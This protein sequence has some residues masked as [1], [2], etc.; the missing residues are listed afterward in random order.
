MA[1]TPLLVAVALV[2]GCSSANQA[3]NPLEPANPL[4]DELKNC[5]GQASSTI[6][7]DGVYVLTTFG[8]P[9]EGQTM[10]CGSSTQ[11]GTWYYAASRQRYGCG[12]K[13]QLTANGNC[14]VAQT[15]DYGPDVCV[16]NAAGLPIIDASPLV[17]QALFGTS[18][19]G[20]SDHLQV[21]VTQV[22]GST[23][24]G[25][26]NGSGTGTGGAAGAGSCD[27][28]V[29]PGCGSSGSGGSGGSG[30]CDPF[31][32]PNCGYGTGGSGG[33]DPFTDPNCGSG[34]GGLGGSGG[35]DPYYDPNCGYGGGGS[36]GS[37]GCDP[38]Y[39]PNCGY[40]ASGGSS[41]SM[42]GDGYCDLDEDCYVCPSDCWDPYC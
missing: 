38:Y 7:S 27:P 32:D 29:D 36:G 21:N 18:G 20:W 37:G 34:V 14:V 1:R 6:P 39:D 5:N 30:S 10:A 13:I 33:C 16:E 23:A 41:G 31:T 17:A 24:L 8:G 2:V 35:C 26:C 42:C 19:A 22:D 40:G 4:N 11:N 15:D 28:A 12:S 9:G 25:P 3:P